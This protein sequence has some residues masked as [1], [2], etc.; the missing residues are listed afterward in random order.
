MFKGS[1]KWL[2]TDS[3]EDEA[4]QP[5]RQK[6]VSYEPQTTERAIPQSSNGEMEKKKRN[7]KKSFKKTKKA[8]LAEQKKKKKYKNKFGESQKQLAHQMVLNAASQQDMDTILSYTAVKLNKKEEKKQKRKGDE[9]RNR[10]IAQQ[11][12]GYR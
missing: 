5:P 2:D 4:G 11:N 1:D 6:L 8:L 3:S 9:R 7:Y 12:V 10:L